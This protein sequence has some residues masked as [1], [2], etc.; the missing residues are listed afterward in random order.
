MLQMTEYMEPFVGEPFDAH[1]T[2]VTK[3]GIFVGLE[4]GV[5]GLVHISTMDDD[6]YVY[7][8]ESMQLTG[9]FNGVQYSLGM[10]VRVTLIKADKDKHEIDF[11]MGEIHSPL[12]L[13]KSNRKKKKPHSKKVKRRYI[14]IRR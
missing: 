14:R 13:E 2:G 3:F 10:P 9:H 8:E 1:I 11:I 6:E 5:E 7:N 12:Q 4:N